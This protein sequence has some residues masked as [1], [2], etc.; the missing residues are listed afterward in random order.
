MKRILFVIVL[1]AAACVSC[2]TSDTASDTAS[3]ETFLKDWTFNGEAVRV[4]HD[5]AISGEFDRANDLQE[6][7]VLQ[8]GEE[9][10]TAHTGR[11]GGLP[12]MGRGVYE[13][14]IEIDR[15]DR[16]WEL[17]FDGAM[18]DAHVFVNGEEAGHWPYGYN[19]FSV[20]ITPFVHQGANSVRVELENVEQSSR[21]YPGAGLYRP[22]KLID[23]PLEDAIPTWGIYVTTPLVSAQKAVVSVDAGGL[24][25]SSRLFDALGALVAEGSSNL[26]VS[27]PHLWSPSSPYLYTLECRTST[28]VRTM[29]V[30]IRSY[31]FRAGEG[32]FLN[33]EPTKFKGVCNHHDLGPLG[34][35]ENESILRYRLGM[36]K[37]MGCNAL[38]TSHNMPST[39]LVDLCDELGFMVI[40]ES[41]DEWKSAK[42]ENGYNRFY[43][44]WVEKDLVNL[45]HHFR[46]NPSVVLWSI[47]NEMPDQS[48][49]DGVALLGRMQDIVHREDPTRLANLGMDHFDNVLVNGFAAAIDVPGFNY[50]VNR[51]ENEA[52]GRLPQGFLLGTESAST[53]SS[54]GVY[55]FPVEIGF[56]KR[57][58]DHQ[59][60]S[61][62]VEYCWW[63][64]KPDDD[65]RA[66]EDFDWCLGQFVWTGFDYL[67]E[68]TPYDIDAWPNHS[69]MF[70][71]ID[72]ASIPKDRYWL[73]RSVWNTSS[74]TLHVLPHWTWPG[75]EGEKTPVY[76][77]TSY[78]SAELF[79][80][81]ESQGR[82]S[83]SRDNYMTRHRLMW[84]DVV[85]QPGEL[86]VVAYDADGAVSAEKIVKT[87]GE[88][89]ALEMSTS[90]SSVTAGGDDMALVTVT[91]VDAS[92][93]P[94][95][96]ASNLVSVSVSGAGSFEA[97]ANGDP[98]CLESFREPSMHLFSGALSFV[99]RSGE[100][101]GNISVEVSSEGLE[102][103]TLNIKCK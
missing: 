71:I 18:S 31:E 45:V 98:T 59:C 73:Y 47:G 79:V 44:E 60:S 97:I 65:F 63:S 72:L 54:R 84:D 29:K 37:D 76:V 61:Y 51:F 23:R 5:W 86:R 26:E 68:P 103:A 62:D 7:Q 12:W 77:Y 41:F 70:G 35:A 85:Y 56:D 21:W 25:V 53:L 102:S 81:G 9:S 83:F 82:R 28:D 55:K 33:G 57:Y 10:V 52:I 74:P 69:S 50:R 94:V 101:R 15:A 64:N 4:P 6:V 19:A 40:A 91:A 89:Y 27:N 20:D 22:V 42:C 67:G 3:R 46:S 90:F 58:D 14:S 80:N 88:A 93:N 13:T 75:R 92:G 95:P 49:A 39:L 34:A 43:D 30:G 66:S 87:A 48:S 11:S 38:R 96:H 24:N 32:F 36:L 100:R 17:Y 99:V 16:L 1:C 8:N 2:K 78:P